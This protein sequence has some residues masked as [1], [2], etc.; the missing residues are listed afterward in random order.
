M[1]QYVA[2]SLDETKYTFHV[3]IPN[4]QCA[5]GGTI[6]TELLITPLRPDITIMDRKTKTFKILELTC[7]LEPNIKARNI[8]KKNKYAHL[9]TD[10]TNVKTSLTCFEVGS[11]GYLSPDNHDRIK[12]L[13]R[14]CKPGLKLR[15]FKENISAISI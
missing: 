10:I 3:D 11:R 14:Y 6:P 8:D 9:L 2:R 15:K 5:N 12:E 1:L 7:P 4:Y 13:H